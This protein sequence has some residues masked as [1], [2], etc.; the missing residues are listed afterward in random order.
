Q[1]QSWARQDRH[2]GCGRLTKISFGSSSGEFKETLNRII[3][4]SYGFFDDLK[5]S[6]S[7]GPEFE[8]PAAYHFSSTNPTANELGFRLLTCLRIFSPHSQAMA[9]ITQ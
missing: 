7:A 8:F 1:R 5:N 6:Q 2:S 3:F 4:G 9:E